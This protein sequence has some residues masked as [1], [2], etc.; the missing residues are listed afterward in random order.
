MLYY[1]KDLFEEFEI[2]PDD[3][4]TWKDVERIGEELQDA[5]GQRF[6]ALDGTLFD[7]LLRQRG[8]DLF[9][10]KGSFLPNEKSSH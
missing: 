3:L 1:R 10:S 5:H 9:D 7:V 2:E 4:Q 8:S 6:L